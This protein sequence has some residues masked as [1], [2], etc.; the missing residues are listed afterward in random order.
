MRRTIVKVYPHL[1][2]VQDLPSVAELAADFGYRQWGPPLDYPL[3]T[4]SAD[5]ARAMLDNGHDRATARATLFLHAIDYLESDLPHGMNPRRWAYFGW[6]QRTLPQL[7]ERYNYPNL[8]TRGPEMAEAKAAHRAAL[9]SAH[10]KAGWPPAGCGRVPRI[11]THRDGP[12]EAAARFARM[13]IETRI[14]KLPTALEQ[15][16][17]FPKS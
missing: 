8:D 12:A 10:E 14:P 2:G 13:E 11:E 15:T 3:A 1:K 17:N 4:Q 7:A 6:R 16:W 9:V 5:A